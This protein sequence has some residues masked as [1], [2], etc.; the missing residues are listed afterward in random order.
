MEEATLFVEIDN[1]HRLKLF[2]QLSR[3]NIRINVENLTLGRLS[4]TGQYRQSAGT[5]GSFK[6]ALIDLCDFTNKTVLLLVEVVCGEYAGGNRPCTCTEFFKCA[7]D[8]KILLEEY[9]P[10]NG[11]RLCI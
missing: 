4:K 11:E 5:D 9:A 2:S 7:D 10:R 1:L 3:C 8:S 6:W